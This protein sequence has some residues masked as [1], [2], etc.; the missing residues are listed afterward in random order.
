VPPVDLLKHF[1]ILGVVVALA[2]SAIYWFRSRRVIEESPEDAATIKAIIAYVAAWTAVPFLVM[3]L[4]M[5][6]GSTYS[7]FDYMYPARGNQYVV[8]FHLLLLVFAL[9]ALYWVTVGGGMQKVERYSEVLLGRRYDASIVKMR[10]FIM[11]G[12]AV[13]VVVLMWLGIAPELPPEL[14]PTG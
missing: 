5:S 9:G 10:V 12:A 4:G 2:N 13:A 1:W 7:P 3:G 14:T 6:S 8:A 11:I